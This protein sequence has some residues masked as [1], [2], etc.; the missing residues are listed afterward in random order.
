MNTL[1]IQSGLT[2]G[3]YYQF[4]LRAKNYVGLSPFSRFVRIIAASV[5]Q[6]PVNLIRVSST[7]SSVTFSWSPNAVNGGASV[8]DYAVYWD[9]GDS[10]LLPSQFIEAHD[11]TYNI[12]SFTET[13]LTK[14]SYYRFAVQAQN[15]AGYSDFSSV[16]R[17]LVAIVNTEPLSLRMTY[18]DELSIRLAWN[19][20]AI[21]VGSAVTNY[22]VS[23]FN[24][25]TSSWTVIGST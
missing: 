18:Q 24:D 19:Q 13:Q 11:T 25:F 10:N 6:P 2:P 5:P 16:I 4:K 14:G 22:L 17:L 3:S 23:Q 20:P 15:D 8:F 9:G 12:T 21:D 1:F 7:T